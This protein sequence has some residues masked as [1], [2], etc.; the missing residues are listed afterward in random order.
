[1]L[2][3]EIIL[4]ITYDNRKTNMIRIN[5]YRVFAVPCVMK[6]QKKPLTATKN[7]KA[8]SFSYA[9]ENVSVIFLLF[10]YNYN[11][12]KRLLFDIAL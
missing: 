4:M 11:L 1:M 6:A 5:I 10:Y 7:T 2:A 3:T 9:D 8:T 12:L